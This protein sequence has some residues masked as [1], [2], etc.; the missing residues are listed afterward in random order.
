MLK[1]L[2]TALLFALPAAAQPVEDLPAP[3]QAA[4]ETARADCAAFD[5]GTLDVPPEAITRTDLTGNG[6][7]DMVL[8][9]GQV[10]CSSA[11]TLYCGTGGCPVVFAVEETATERLSKGWTVQRFAHLTVV[12]NQVH[13]SACG[14]TNLTPCVEAL[15]WDTEARRFTSL[16]DPGNP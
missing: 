10:H 16:A 7:T 9:L 15:V 5:N 6:T 14:G 1:P 3:L 13:G 4:I 11:V 12:L 8:D 2:L